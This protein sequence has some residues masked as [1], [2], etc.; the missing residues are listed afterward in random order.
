[1]DWMKPGYHTMA[2]YNM[3]DKDRGEKH[4]VDD[5]IGILLTDIRNRIGDSDTC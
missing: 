1:M 4:L 5:E 3:G 2:I